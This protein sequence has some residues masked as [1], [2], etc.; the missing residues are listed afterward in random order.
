MFYNVRKYYQV[1]SVKH[2]FY[3][4]LEIRDNILKDM[5]WNDILSNIIELHNSNKY[6]IFDHDDNIT[7]YEINS[8]I[9]RY[10][11]YLIAIVNN[12]ILSQQLCCSNVN[13]I[14]PEVI[15]FYLLIIDWSYLNNCRLNY[16]FINNDDRIKLRFS[17]D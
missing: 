13:Y 2:V 7:S 14:L 17:Y 16:T 8:C 5:K 1:Q 15:N 3:D 10:E 12:E 11:N 6:K 4:K 9:L